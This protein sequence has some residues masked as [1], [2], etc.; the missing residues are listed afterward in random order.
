MEWIWLII[1]G[2]VVGALGR[3]I[4]PG[5]DPMGL[6]VTILLGIASLVIAGLIFDGALQFI[7][8]V[9]VAVIL[10]T[11]VGRLW[12]DRGRTVTAP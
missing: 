5:R 12:G 9:I 7:V 10:V 1:V 6:I 8:G 11:L 3:F 4:N 2:A